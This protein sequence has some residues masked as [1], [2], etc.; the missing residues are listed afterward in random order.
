MPGFFLLN[1]CWPLSQ[2][3][4]R[5]YLRAHI[6]AERQIDAARQS[7]AAK[8]TPRRQSSPKAANWAIFQAVAVH[9]EQFTGLKK[10]ARILLIGGVDTFFSANFEKSQPNTL[11]G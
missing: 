6:A 8:P 10:L 5:P 7:I 2:V 4:A 3:T 9:L 1:F 11:K